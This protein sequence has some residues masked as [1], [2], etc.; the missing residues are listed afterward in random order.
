MS[1]TYSVFMS[2]AAA[3]DLRNI[4][5]YIASTLQSPVAARNQLRRIQIQIQALD[6]LPKRHEA[7]DWEPWLSLGMRKV[8]V[9]HFVIFYT[10][11]EDSHT[12]TIIRIVYG[13]R[14]MQAL[15]KEIE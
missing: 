3:N 10:V 8:P 7:V 15:L 6:H 2:P 13:G 5:L 4:Y 9:D 1:E 11:G 12:V 14:N